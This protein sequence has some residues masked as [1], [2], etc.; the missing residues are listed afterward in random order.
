[1]MK[2]IVYSLMFLLSISISKA[3]EFKL[4]TLLYSN[5][6]E[7]RVNYVILGDGYLVS[8]LPDFLD[9]ANQ[10]TRDLF[11][12]S[13]FSLY[14]NFFNVFAISVPSNEEG[15]ALQPNNPIDN[16]FGSTFN[17]AGI[18]R[19]LVPVRTDRLNS[20]LAANFPTYDQAIVLVNSTKYGGSGGEFATSS[21]NNEASEIAIHEIGHSFAGLSDEYWAGAQFARESPNM[22]KETTTQFLKW[23]NWLDEQGIGVYAHSVDASWKKPHLNCKMQFLGGEF[24]AVCKEQFIKI[25]YSLTSPVES[26]TPLS[27][28]SVEEDMLVFNLETVDPNPNTLKI[29]WYLNDS[30]VGENEGFYELEAT[31]LSSGSNMVQAIV[32]DSTTLDRQD[33][34]FMTTVTWTINGVVTSMIDKALSDRPV[35]EVDNVITSVSSKIENSFFKVYPNPSNGELK[36]T[37][38][39]GGERLDIRLL[40]GEGKE[41][42]FV[43]WAPDVSG[44]I[45]RE[46]DVSELASGLYVIQ[47][48]SGNFKESHRFLKR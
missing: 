39:L 4:D 21:V 23:Q 31:A 12:T 42:K 44:S 24:C 29:S 20:V 16:Y 37:Y 26:Y 10:I 7:G 32:Y 22:T 30:P 27:S 28:M 5:E 35:E 33:H 1:M 15:A 47:L 19:L 36:V 38:H 41:V 13:P 6:A 48:T 8:Q 40:N 18:E 3:Q 43:S 9:D 14:K 11:E 34:I 45:E 46:L 17:F 25:I 2:R